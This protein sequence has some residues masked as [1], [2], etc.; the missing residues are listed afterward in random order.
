MVE[1]VDFKIE[2]SFPFHG[3]RRLE[4]AAK[5]IRTRVGCAVGGEGGTRRERGSVPERSE[6]E[7]TRGGRATLGALLQHL[8]YQGRNM[9]GAKA[10]RGYRMRGKEGGGFRFWGPVGNSTNL[11]MLALFCFEFHLIEARPVFAG[12]VE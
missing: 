4:T 7:G 3:Y 8:P 10:F 12:E 5:I 11:E 9:N 1:F 6:R 2:L